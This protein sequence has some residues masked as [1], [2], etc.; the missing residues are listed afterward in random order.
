MSNMQHTCIT[1][2]MGGTF[3]KLKERKHILDEGAVVFFCLKYDIAI[4][5]QIQMY[6]T[7]RIA[8]TQGNPE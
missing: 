6:R 4:F 8:M 1:K 3:K 2:K 5:K 7:R